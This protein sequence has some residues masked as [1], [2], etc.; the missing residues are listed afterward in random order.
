[1]AGIGITGL[2]YKKKPPDPNKQLRNVMGEVEKVLIRHGGQHLTQRGKVTRTWKEEKPNFF[3]V[4]DVKKDTAKMEIK[5][6][7]E[8]GFNKWI[9]LDEGTTVRYATMT[10]GFKAKTKV[11]VIGS[12]EGAG[13][14]MFV[15]VRFPRPGIA[16]R[17]FSDE[18][19]KRQTKKLTPQLDKA[20]SRGLDKRA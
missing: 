15:N 19:A 17:H 16:A 13:K 12:G 1:M 8:H 11:R 18:I 10:P 2:R 5:V 4:I 3:S 9:W 14:L 20:V 6:A 7:G